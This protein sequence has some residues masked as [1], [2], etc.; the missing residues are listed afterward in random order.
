[1]VGLKYTSNCGTFVAFLQ[2]QGLLSVFLGCPYAFQEGM[3]H[4][5]DMYLDDFV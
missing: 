1:M 3:R 4:T 5:V 2:F